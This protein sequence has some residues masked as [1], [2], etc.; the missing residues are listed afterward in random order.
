MRRRS[1]STMVAAGP[2]HI[3]GGRQFTVSVSPDGSG[4]ASII[5]NIVSNNLPQATTPTMSPAGIIAVGTG[6]NVTFTE[7]LLLTQ[8]NPP[9]TYQWQFE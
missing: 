1:R 6:T 5:L 3:D 2:V 7:A 9:F 8:N 4:T